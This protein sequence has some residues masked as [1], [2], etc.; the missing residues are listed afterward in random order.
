[1]KNTSKRVL[2]GVLAIMMLAGSVVTV[3]AHSGRTDSRGGHKDNKNISGLGYYHYHCGGYPDHLH[4]DGVC[5]YKNNSSYGDYSEWADTSEWTDSSA[6]T[7]GTAVTAVPDQSDSG[8]QDGVIGSVVTTDIKAYINGAEIPA[9][10]VD[11]NMIIIGADLRS[12]GFDVVYDN[13]SRTSS[14]SLSAYGGT[15]DPIII[16]ADDSTEVGTEIMSVY[17]TDI[18]MVVNGTPVTGYNVDGRMAFRFAELAVFGLYYYDNENRS[19]NLW[20]G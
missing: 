7:G 16:T 13:N 18:T 4:T 10:N 6:W 19:T 12:Y 5:P 9:Y 17:E 2:S 14:V 15:W 20:V 3:Y 1:M 8:Q 11:G